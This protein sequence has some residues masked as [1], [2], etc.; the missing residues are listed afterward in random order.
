MTRM[1]Y[2]GAALVFLTIGTTLQAQDIHHSKRS[3]AIQATRVDERTG[4]ADPD[5]AEMNNDVSAK[6]AAEAG[7]LRRTS[8]ALIIP[9]MS[10]GSIVQLHTHIDYTTL[11]ILPP[12]ERILDW[13][14]GDHNRWVLEG[15]ENFAYLR[16]AEPNIKTNVNLVTNLGHVYSF[17]VEEVS[18]SRATPI[19]QKVI[20]H[21]PASPDLSSSS[22]KTTANSANSP[23]FVSIE[24][25]HKAQQLVQSTAT[26]AQTEIERNRQNVA[27]AMHFDYVIK[28][29]RHNKPF[30]VSAIYNDGTFTY[31]QMAPESEEKPALY[32]VREGKPELTNYTYNNGVYTVNGV[33]NR[34]YLR[35]GKSKLDFALK[36][37]K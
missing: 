10:D 34:A 3:A 14:V 35:A 1:N 27:N 18:S 26:V 30:H 7:M 29:S 24:D 16:P 37:A 15:V 12:G 36:G 33:V 20:I 5:A 17:D 28:P 6:V 4:Q 13:L 19:D 2:L 32:I 8:N 23:R 25:L 31:I 22:S 21:Q 11:I 9:D